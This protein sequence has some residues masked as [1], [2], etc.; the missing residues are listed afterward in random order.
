[1]KCGFCFI[2]MFGYNLTLDL[3]HFQGEISKQFSLQRPLVACIKKRC[4]A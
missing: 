2:N 4:A 1:M 3:Y